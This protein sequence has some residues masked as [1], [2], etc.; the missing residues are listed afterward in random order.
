MLRD[1]RKAVE[2]VRYL[3]F[4]DG[5]CRREEVIEAIWPER[6]PERGRALL[7]NALSEV[8]AGLEPGRQA[9][10]PSRFLDT[11]RTTVQLDATSD[12]GEAQMAS[13]GD[14]LRLLGQPVAPGIDADWAAEITLTRDR[15]L[16]DQA[17]RIRR[18]ASHPD[19]RAALD[20]LIGLEPWNRAP[21]DELIAL[22]EKE[23]D[24]A[25]AAA[26]E[27]RWFEDD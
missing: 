9:G 26:V 19:R 11:S 13:P 23:G 15:H 22:L 6:E 16:A 14:A 20:V 12:L 17:D 4:R 27:R 10:E 25:G 2:I 3:A 21:V 24:H 7:R 8:R 18:D 5:P 1:A